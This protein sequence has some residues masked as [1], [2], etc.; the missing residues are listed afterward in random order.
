[1]VVSIQRKEI[2]VAE[3]QEI[4]RVSLNNRGAFVAKIQF[5]YID[6][7]GRKHLTEKTGEIGVGLTKAA[8]PGDMGVPDGCTVYLC[9]FVGA[10]KDQY[11]SQGFQYKKG[12]PVVARYTISGGTLN[13]K[14]ELLGIS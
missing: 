6:E 9:A 2:V 3:A 10:G 12:S 5:K 1:M 7:K 13:A 14:L 8:D 4:G 11:A